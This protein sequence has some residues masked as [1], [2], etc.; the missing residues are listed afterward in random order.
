V[1]LDEFVASVSE[2]IDVVDFFAPST[3]FESVGNAW[4]SASLRWAGESDMSH[5]ESRMGDPGNRTD[6]LT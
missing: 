6:P 5:L 1:R 4:T 2:S 3:H